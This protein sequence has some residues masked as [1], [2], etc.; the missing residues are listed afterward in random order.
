[1]FVGCTSARCMLLIPHQVPNV[2]KEHDLE[3]AFSV[4]KTLSG[5]LE[6]SCV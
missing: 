3:D 6:D 4:W 2:Q 5:G 1:M